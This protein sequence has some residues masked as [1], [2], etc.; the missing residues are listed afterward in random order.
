MTYEGLIQQRRIKTYNASEKEIR[1][2]LE[3]AARDLSA[4]V[5]M[6]DFHPD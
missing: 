6:I 5:E 4:A 1:R 3:I 2:L